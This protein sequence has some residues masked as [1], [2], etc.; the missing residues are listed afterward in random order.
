LSDPVK[1]RKTTPRKNKQLVRETL[2][3]LSG[4]IKEAG[5]VYRLMR[6]G[7]LPHEEGRSLVWVLAQMRAMIEAQHL[8]RIE[9]K[10]NQLQATAESRGML[11]HGHASADQ[12]SRLAH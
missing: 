10:L 6:A 11:P 4:L 8:E 1:T 3:S 7:R 2:S 12:P 9:A 5:I